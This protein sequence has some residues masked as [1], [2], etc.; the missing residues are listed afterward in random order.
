MPVQLPNKWSYE[1]MLDYAVGVHAG[2]LAA[3]ETS[4]QAPLWEGL[5]AEGRKLRDERDDVRYATIRAS[6]RQRYLDASWDGEITLISGTAHLAAGKD[7]QKEPYRS[8]FGSVTAK[9]AKSFGPHRA[10]SVGESLVL[11]MKKLAHA[12]LVPFIE[13]FEARNKALMEAGA[14]REAAEKQEK[15]L[16]ID[17][18]TY[19]LRLEKAAAVT[20]IALLR[21][22]VDRP[23]AKELV[24]SVLGVPRAPRKRKAVPTPALRPPVRN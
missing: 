21:I 17:Q 1:S 23:N 20:E 8:T 2:L 22:W 12:A 10:S 14:A 4:Q 24:T 13:K 9:E 3:D 16:G 11:S 18:D 5:I 15:L 7:E 19:H 6:A